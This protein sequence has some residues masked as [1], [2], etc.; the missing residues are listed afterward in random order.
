[1]SLL[2]DNEMKSH[3]LSMNLV[4]WK[5]KSNITPKNGRVIC[6]FDY[7]VIF[8]KLLTSIDKSCKKSSLF[9]KFLKGFELN[10]KQLRQYIMNKH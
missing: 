4:E 6:R 7:F 8:T 10:A 5:I 3:L 9:S 2:K 1:M